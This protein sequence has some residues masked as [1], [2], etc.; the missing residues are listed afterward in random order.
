M[1]LVTR[2]TGAADLA[3]ALVAT[4]DAVL[5]W[6]C[7][8]AD[9]AVAAGA[10][11]ADRRHRHLGLWL[12]VSGGYPA[13]LAARDVKTVAA[14]V[15]LEHV[16]VEA[17]DHALA[18]AAVVEALL[19]DGPVE[20]A[21]EVATITGAFNRPVPKEPVRVWASEGG[22][23]VGGGRSLGLVAS[24]VDALGEWRRYGA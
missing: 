21:N 10:L 23:L 20:I 18:H 4:R 17:G 14:L 8:D 1:D 7:T 13:A 5:V 19:G 9:T 24:G 2:A 22:R 3:R 6:R 11:A 15:G 12:E 16:V